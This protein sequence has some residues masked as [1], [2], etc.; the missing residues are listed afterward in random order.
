MVK[1]TDKNENQ[2]ADEIK[3]ANEWLEVMDLK[4][5]IST[6]YFSM[7]VRNASDGSNPIEYELEPSFGYSFW[8]D[9]IAQNIANYLKNQRGQM[10]KK[11]KLLKITGTRFAFTRKGNDAYSYEEASAA[12]IRELFDIDAS[13]FIVKNTKIIYYGT[14]ATDGGI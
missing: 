1:I 2:I 3:N 5:N 14:D 4:I 12:L 10:I 13:W 6:N 9:Q 8:L 11:I 7:V